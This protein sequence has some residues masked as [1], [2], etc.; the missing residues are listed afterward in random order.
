MFPRIVDTRKTAGRPLESNVDSAWILRRS[1]L[2]WI[3]GPWS[4]AGGV[5][6]A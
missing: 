4:S 3:Y 5:R 2:A 6:A 1:E